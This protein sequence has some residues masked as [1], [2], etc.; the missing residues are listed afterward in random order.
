MTKQELFQ[1]GL[2][3]DPA[4]EHLLDKHTWYIGNKGYIV[5]TVYTSDGQ[6]YTESLAR[7]ICNAPIGSIVDHANQNRLD[8]SFLNLVVV[9]RRHN[10]L[11][12]NKT[13][14]IRRTTSG[15]YQARLGQRNLG[16]YLT[17]EEAKQVR[18]AAVKA[19]LCNA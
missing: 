7:L 6:Q 13:D 3:I 11:N 18:D 8:N 17:Y 9:S 4:F 15:K 14:G 5:A 2:I 12:T 19:E 16:S 1:Q 10:R